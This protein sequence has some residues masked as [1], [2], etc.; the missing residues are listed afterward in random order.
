[1][2][3][4]LLPL[5]ISTS[6]LFAQNLVINGGFEPVRENCPYPAGSWVH[7]I[8]PPWHGMFGTPD[9]FG[10]CSLPG[11]ATTNN[12]VLPHSGDGYIG[13]ASYG[14]Y[15]M[16]GTFNRE[17]I[18]GHLEQTLEKDQ[19]YR[20]SYWLHPVLVNLI[21]INAGIDGPGILFIEEAFDAV[22]TTQWHIESDEAIYPSERITDLG[23]WTQV[24]L[25]YKANGNENYLILGTFSDDNERSASLLAG[26]TGSLNWAYSL[27]D[28]MVI[29]PIGDPVLSGE[30]S[31]CS[32]ETATLTVPDGLSGYWDDGSTDTQRDVNL[33]G[34]YS[35]TYMEGGCPRTDEIRVVGTNCAH[36]YVYIPDAF[37]PNGDGLNDTW[38]PVMDCFPDQYRLEVFDRQGNLVFRTFD[39]QDT[40]D[41][42]KSVQSGTYVARMKMTYE[43]K[44]KQVPIDRYLDITVLH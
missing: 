8:A 16:S 19:W 9:H 41:P 27:I 2:N 18:H 30:I 44:R 21:D 22:Q 15:P 7:E 1:M 4:F 36:C 10:P 40:W 29:E 37:S 43:Y 38:A 13:L 6:S 32:E 14:Y 34:V 35:Y 28:D 17:Y 31:I 20:I 24:C 26:A 5:F 39:H 3:K 25:T 33:P 23:T 12:N 11:S 42:G